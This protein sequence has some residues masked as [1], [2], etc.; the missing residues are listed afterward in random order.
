MDEYTPDPSDESEQAAPQE[1]AHDDGESMNDGD[2]IPLGANETL[3]DEEA[4][5]ESPTD[6]EE[7]DVSAAPGPM[8][9]TPTLRIEIEEAEGDLTIIGGADQ[10][11]VT[12][13]DW[14]TE[15]DA[16]ETESGLRF[17]RLP[18]NAELHI[19]HGALIIIREVEGDLRC[20]RLNGELRVSRA[21]GDARI[22]DVAAAQVSWVEGDLTVDHVGAFAGES[23]SGDAWLAN[24]HATTTLGRIDGDL[25]VRR[26]GG[27]IIT[28]SIGGDVEIERCGVVTLTGSVG[29]DVDLRKIERSIKLSSVGG[30]L[31]V[32]DARDLSAGAIAGDVEL[33]GL[34]GSVKLDTVGADM[35]MRNTFGAVSVGVIGGDL[36][37]ERASGGVS[38]ARTGG[39][40]MLDTLLRPEAKYVVNAGGDITLRVRGEVNARFVAQ[41]F[42]GE[43]STR[44]PLTVEKGRRRNLVGALGTGSATVTLQSGGDISI[45]AADGQRGDFQMSDNYD[46]QGNPINPGADDADARAHTFEGAVGGRKFRV[47]V[48]NGPGRAGFQFK[49]PFTPEQEESAREFRLDWERGRGAHASGEYGEQLNDLRDQA[50]KLARRAGE[51]ARKY[52]EMAREKVREADW[53]SVGSEIRTT[54]E[55]A[56][57][58]LEEA[59]GRVRRDWEPRGDQGG[60]S[61]GGSSARPSG[62]GPQRVRIEHDEP[63]DAGYGASQPAQPQDRDALRRQTLEDLRNGRITLDDAERRLNDLR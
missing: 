41:S 12:S 17:S 34:V 61:A 56:M 9:E 8:S 53:E 47:R 42:G 4:Q 49:G 5:P 7:G 63:Q 13:P 57:S 46:D 30:D 28:E 24:V 33:E 27:I 22:E 52:A 21:E 11:D 31:K 2:T 45:V 26:S 62:S 14:D 32:N 35:D 36:K 43:I 55:R 48:E 15:Y 1:P 16:V 50:E 6:V 37:V 40:V 3:F 51:E 19:P 54:I 44:L 60:P 38:V 29:G 25:E 39:D 20:E 59:F 23:V 58:D 10:V 18:D